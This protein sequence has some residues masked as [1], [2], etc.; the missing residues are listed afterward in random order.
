M[1]SAVADRTSVDEVMKG[2]KIIDTDAHWTEPPDLWTK[3]APASFR[4]RMPQMRTVD[5]KSRW[6]VDG[7]IDFSGPGESVV[8]ID[9]VK[10]HGLFTLESFEEMSRAASDAKERV[11]ILDEVGV[12]KQIVYPGAAGHGVSKFRD[13]KDEALRLQCIK[14]Y[15]DAA[16]AWQ[17]ESGNRLFPQALLPYWDSK[18]LTEEARRCVED[19]KL[20]GFDMLD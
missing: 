16:S 17:E 11:K 15:N 12:W 20:T 8:N 3:H 5:G 13:V 1:A 19:L 14:T 4:D 7:D 10:G 9:N 2:I 18:L 6:F